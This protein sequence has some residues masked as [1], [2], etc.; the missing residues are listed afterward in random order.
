MRYSYARVSTDKRTQALTSAARRSRNYSVS[1]MAAWVGVDPKTD[2]QWIT[3][4]DGRSAIT[5][6]NCAKS[7]S[8]GF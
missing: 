1:I 6:Q 3:T 8:V 4:D 5:E 2:I 7:F